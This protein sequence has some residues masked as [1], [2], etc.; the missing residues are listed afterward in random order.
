MTNTKL[1]FVSAEQLE[2]LCRKY[3]T[4]F[5][6]YDARGIVENAR[7]VSLE[8]RLPRIFC[9]ESHTYAGHHGLVALRGLR[10]GLLFTDRAYAL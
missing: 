8:Q 3:P 9:R 1:P 4:P 10:H 7:R 2:L 5:H 6:L